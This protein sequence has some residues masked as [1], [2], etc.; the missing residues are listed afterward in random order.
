[1]IHKGRFQVRVCPG[2]TKLT[3]VHDR[4]WLKLLVGEGVE[5]LNKCCFDRNCCFRGLD[6]SAPSILAATVC[7]LVTICSQGMDDQITDLE[8][9]S[10]SAQS[11]PTRL[12]LCGF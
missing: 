7:S 10:P 5:N 9:T 6:G 3:G 12:I 11:L 4:C 2:P 1:M 8:P